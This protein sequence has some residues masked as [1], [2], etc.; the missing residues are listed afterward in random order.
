MRILG[1]LLCCLILGL[2]TVAFAEQ[3]TTVFSKVVATKNMQG[4]IP[5]IDGLRYTNL[6][7][8]V[9]GILNSKVKDL[10]AQVGGSGTVS[11]EVKLNR[12]SLVGILLKAT[13]GGHTAYQAVNLDMTTGNEFSIRDFVG[14]GNA[15]HEILGAY[16]G[17]LFADNGIYTRTSSGAAYSN[18]VSYSKLFPLLRTGEAGRLLTVYGL[19]RAV[20]DKVV[21]MKAG[22]LLALQLESNRTTG[23]SWFVE[24]NGYAGQFYELG[25]SY[26][27]PGNAANNRTGMPGLEIIVFGAQ[28]P[29]EYKVNME[30]KRAWEKGSGFDKFSF[31]VKVL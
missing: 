13:N 23:Y 18:F 10:L 1:I 26:V 11:Y 30:Y 12:P 24:G 5:E 20:E 19:T 15:V 3:P 25:R 22:E 7:K 21:T 6:Q 2:S 9:N 16:E 27:L 28:E 17:V 14:E 29:G 8:S 31:T 4:E